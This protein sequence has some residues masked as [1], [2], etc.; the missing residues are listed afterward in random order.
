MGGGA[1]LQA[2]ADDVET[3]PNTPRMS[4]DIYRKLKKATL[5]TLRKY[6][7]GAEVRALIEAPEKVDYGDLDICIAQEEQIDF[8]QLANH[9]GAAGLLIHNAAKATLAIDRDGNCEDC[10]CVIYRHGYD[11]SPD[12]ALPPS[13][14]EYAQL[15]IEVLSPNIL[16][17]HTFYSSYGD[18]AGLLGRIVN[19]LGFTG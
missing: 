6:Y 7:P 10:K 9:L 13:T 8:T 17:W 1:F 3:R 11:K 12:A 16:G 19:P 15:D 5:D 2:R 4:P 18:L 14:A